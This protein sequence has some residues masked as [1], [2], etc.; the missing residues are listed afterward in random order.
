MGDDIRWIL[1][2][3]EF[4]TRDQCGAWTPMMAF[5]YRTANV[6]TVLAC[7]VIP[8]TILHIWRKRK[9]DIPSAW[10]LTLFASSL[11]FC[12]VGHLCHTMAFYW[13]AYRFFIVV[14]WLT[15]VSM[16]ATLI[17]LPFA[18]RSMLDFP[19]WQDFRKKIEELES[20]RSITHRLVTDLER[21]DREREKEIQE[22]DGLIRDLRHG[23][24]DL[25]W[26]IQNQS[27]VIRMLQAKLEHIRKVGRPDD[28][29]RSGQEDR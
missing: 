11:F 16:M 29:G 3:S 19:S 5:L 4:M 22:R 27:E 9:R 15:A 10:I 1:D 2:S 18:V 6:V 7:F 26:P 24:R 25:E 23:M 28:N 17:G 8:G 13:P 21:K 12:G 20:E 14:D